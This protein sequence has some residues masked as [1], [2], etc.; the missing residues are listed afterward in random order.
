VHLTEMVPD[1]TRGLVS[2]LAYQL[3]TLVGARAPVMEFSLS[4]RFGYRWALAGFEIFT[5]LALI[6]IL[7]LGKERKGRS[8]HQTSETPVLTT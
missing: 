4:A 1:E 3:G 5:I 2:G 6:V 7:A 8:F